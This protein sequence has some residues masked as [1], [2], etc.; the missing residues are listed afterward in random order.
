MADDKRFFL[1]VAGYLEGD[2]SPDERAELEA[3]LRSSE[4][5]RAALLEEA[6]LHQRMATLHEASFAGPA[7]EARDR[8]GAPAPR[9]RRSAAKRRGSW[10]RLALPAAAAAVVLAV[11]YVA[12]TRHA[13]D[14]ASYTAAVPPQAAPTLARVTSLRGEARVLRDGTTRLLALD[15]TLVEGDRVATGAGTG[16]TFAYASDDTT[17]ALSADA[18][19]VLAA[20]GEARI[21]QL[22]AGAATA[23]VAPQPDGSSF[24]VTTAHAL[25][26]VVG[27]RFTV[28]ADPRR[29]LVTVTEGRVGITHRATE[30]HEEITAGECALAEGGGGLLRSEDPPKERLAT[31]HEA[32]ATGTVVGTVVGHGSRGWER[33]IEVRSLSGQVDRYIPQWR[34][35][36]ER[37]PGRPDP[38]TVA[39]MEALADGTRV[40]IAW[41]VDD[42][43][44]ILE[45]HKLP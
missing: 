14:A 36:P 41:R 17:V 37:P 25:V 33:W 13:P 40:R 19:A 1:L 35:D 30:A 32:L 11:G 31:D 3:I 43:L 5:Y 8:R 42:H 45:I 7:T 29:T 6:R 22:D 15:D 38:A 23:S 2:L 16:V 18:S 24:A 34:G 12:V 10:A 21:L 26:R 44:R 27:T 39:A 9:R 4:R 28:A 20:G